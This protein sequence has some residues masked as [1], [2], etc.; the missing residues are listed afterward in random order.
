MVA[1]TMVGACLPVF[2]IEMAFAASN[3]FQNEIRW[4]TLSS[5]G[6]LPMS[7]GALIFQKM[8]GYMIPAVPYVVIFLL[9]GLVSP[10]VMSR[11]LDDV[12]TEAPGWYM[13]SMVVMGL[14]LTV[15][16]SIVLK[17][18]ALAVAFLAVFFGNMTFSMMTAFLSLWSGSG[19]AFLV[20]GTTVQFGVAVLLH[21]QIPGLLER[22]V[23][24]A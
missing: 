21:T 17:R 23:A 5:I 6:I 19:Q 14:Y 24:E 22:K 9:G 11:M 4:N 12:L 10:E 1:T 8:V 18:G 7:T 13:I 3:I 16:F 20:L 2:V 15:F